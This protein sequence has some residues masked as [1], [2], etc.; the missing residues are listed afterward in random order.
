MQW[1]HY[2]EESEKLLTT[3]GGTETRSFLFQPET[4]SCGLAV[5]KVANALLA[6]KTIPSRQSPAHYI[7]SDSQHFATVKC[8]P[9]GDMCLSAARAP[10]KPAPDPLPAEM[11][12]STSLLAPSPT[13]NKEPS[14]QGL[15]KCK[16]I[17]LMIFVPFSIKPWKRILAPVGASRQYIIHPTGRSFF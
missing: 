17:L 12:P 7:R 10:C 5:V 9:P 6:Q 4:K 3:N 2:M 15:A 1:W 13:M 8:Q 11:S 14:T 16:K